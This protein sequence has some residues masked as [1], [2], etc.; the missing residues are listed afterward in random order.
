MR[1]LAIAVI[2]IAFIGV[3]GCKKSNNNKGNN[4]TNTTAKIDSIGVTT[5]AA[6]GLNYT[7]A[8]TSDTYA[9]TDF[10]TTISIVFTPNGATI[11][12]ATT[13]GVAITQSDGDVTVTAT[14]TGVAYTVSGSTSNGSLKIYSDKKF[15]VTLNGVDLINLDGPALNIQS[16]KRAFIV[17]ADGTTNNLSDGATYASSTE[18]QKGS[19]FAEGQLVFSGNGTLKVSGNYKHGICS[20]DYI[21]VVS[22]NINILKSKSDGIHVNNAFIADGGNITIN[23]GTDGIEAEEGNVIVNNGT[24]NITSV[25]KGIRTS[26]EGTDGSIARYIVINGGNINVKSTADEGISSKGSLT[27]NKGNISSSASDDAFKADSAIYINSGYVYASST[28]NDG[29]DSNGNFDLNGGTVVAIGSPVT[30]SGIDCDD[31]QFK[32]TGGQLIATGGSTSAVSTSS[33]VNSVILGTGTA[34]LI[35]IES[36]SGAE[37]LTF[38]APVAYA[39]LVFASAK[40]KSNTVY[41]V[42][43]GGSVVSGISFKGLFTGGTYT[44]GTKLATTFT[45]SSVVTK[46]GGI[47]TTN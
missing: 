7:G 5:G 32:I 46:V 3:I 44:K 24:F 41:N 45:T 6:E 31:R 8:N 19:I 16:K 42:Y 9:T 35:H 15:L 17:V 1:K 23:S 36:A 10:P 47:I 21:R 39:T 12:P 18:D 37:A 2:F 26:Y 30:E 11:T 34:Q 13:S 22:G 4:Q 38:Q 43:T 28:A 20:D 14:A 33:T 25:G 40:L 29:M 27:I